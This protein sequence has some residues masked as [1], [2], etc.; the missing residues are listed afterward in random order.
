MDSEKHELA[1]AQLFNQWARSDRGRRMAIG[2]DQLVIPI[3]N[4]ISISKNTKLLDVGCGSGRALYKAVELGVSQVSGID[5]SREMIGYAQNLLN[6]NADLQVGSAVD[7]PWEGEIFTD[8]IS[9]EALYYLLD[10]IFALKEMYRVL[11]YNGTVSIAIDFYKE[12]TGTH[13]WANAVPIQ[14][15]LLPE[16]EWKEMFV[17]VGFREVKSRRIHRKSFLAENE[18][19]ESEYYPT[20]SHY[21]EYIAAGALWISAKKLL[22]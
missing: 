6:I 10:P 5:I 3:L 19:T 11:I 13:A 7:L 17:N 22:P 8:V 14:L 15:L 20:Y 1:T 12:S 2:H 4:E 9:I 21:R 16:S 18:F